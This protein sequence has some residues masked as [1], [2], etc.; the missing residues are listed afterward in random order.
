MITEETKKLL[1]PYEPQSKHRYWISKTMGKKSSRSQYSTFRFNVNNLLLWRGET[2]QL[3]IETLE[4]VITLSDHDGRVV[5]L[6]LKEIPVQAVFYSVGITLVKNKNYWTLNNVF[7]R[8]QV[9]R[10]DL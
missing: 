7:I 3:I 5:L 6:K 10:S 1:N 4:R 8:L 9:K 2:E